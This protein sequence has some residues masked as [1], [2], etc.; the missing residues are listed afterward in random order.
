[1]LV[2][3]GQGLRV[4]IPALAAESRKGSQ[5]KGEM[6]ARAG[7]EQ[8]GSNPGSIPV[9]QNRSSQ[10]PSGWDRETG[11]DERA[12][13]KLSRSSLPSLLPVWLQ[14][15]QHCIINAFTCLCACPGSPVSDTVL[16]P[17]LIK[18]LL[19]PLGDATVGGLGAQQVVPFHVLPTPSLKSTVISSR[20]CL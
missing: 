2:Q 10:A 11:K 1:M 6:Q 17:E 16:V 19:L 13:E 4:S 9:Q 15:V 8:K 3:P 5:G 7:K 14:A 12:G 20:P 18:L